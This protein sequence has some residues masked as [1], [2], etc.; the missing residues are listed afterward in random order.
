MPP[1]ATLEIVGVPG[2]AVSVF[3]EAA[4]DAAS[5]PI[6]E[7]AIPATTRLR[8]RVPRL[9]LRIVASASGVV[10]VR[11]DDGVQLVQVR[12]PPPASG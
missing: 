1:R 6:F 8:L 12:L 3:T 2:A 5:P 4:W 9:P 7:G 10:S 11:F